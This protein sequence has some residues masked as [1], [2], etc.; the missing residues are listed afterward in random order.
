MRPGQVPLESRD[1]SVEG[2]KPKD[3]VGDFGTALGKEARQL[4]GGVFAMSRM[5]PAR[6]PAGIA[7][8]KVEPAEVE[9]KAQ[10]P[11]IL[12]AVVAV[13]VV[14]TRCSRQ[15]ARSLVEANGVGRHPNPLGELTD[16]H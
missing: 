14:P 13:G 1:A 15:P 11:D 2:L 12:F 5:A 9:Q 3:P 16:P 8:R 7:E 4:G 6:D 10:M